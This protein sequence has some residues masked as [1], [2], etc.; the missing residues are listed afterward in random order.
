M[1]EKNRMIDSLEIQ[2][3]T[4]KSK[5]KALEKEIDDL[6]VI[7]ANLRA[8]LKEKDDQISAEMST[9]REKRIWYCLIAAGTGI[10]FGISVTA[11]FKNKKIYVLEMAATDLAAECNDLKEKEKLRNKY[12]KDYA[13]KTC[14]E[15]AKVPEGVTFGTDHW[16]V[17]I[18]GKSLVVFLSANKKKYHAY[19]CRYFDSYSAIN[20][21][22]LP[23]G[24]E[25]C[26]VCHPIEV[27][28]IPSWVFSYQSYIETKKEHHIPDPDIPY[29][30]D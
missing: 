3:E 17:S 21:Y 5:I 28:G 25:P 15:L 23:K 9:A 26:K 14:R 19:G 16:P 24:C 4:L 6:D 30:V 11:Y 27:S 13:G 12:V 20:A 29:P 7:S 22:R 10:F 1:S 8:D 2:N 18:N